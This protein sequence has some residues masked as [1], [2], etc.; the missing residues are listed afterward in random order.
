M[1]NKTIIAKIIQL[2]DA[3]D[4]NGEYE[5]AD[6]LTKIAQNIGQ[7]NSWVEENARKEGVAQ[8]KDAPQEIQQKFLDEIEGKDIPL[9]ELQGEWNAWAENF[10]SQWIIN[11]NPDNTP[12]YLENNQGNDYP[13]VGNDEIDYSGWPGEE[14]I[15]FSKDEGWPAVPSKF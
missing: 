14:E 7:T 1:T 6:I 5:Q 10:F 13:G 8:F 2:A 12:G 3:F 4:T 11:S 15:D 9:E